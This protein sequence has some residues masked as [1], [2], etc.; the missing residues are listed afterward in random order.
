MDARRLLRI[1]LQDHFAAA[2]AGVALARRV[3]AANA[4]GA[5]GQELWRLAEEV[6]ADRWTMAEVLRS[7]DVEPSL[8]KGAVARVAESVSRAKPNGRLAGYSPLSRVLELETLAAGITA[9]AALW[10]SLDLALGRRRGD[11]DFRALHRS[12]LDQARRAEQL[13]AE[14][15]RLA[16]AQP[17]VHAERT[18]A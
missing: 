11:I 12:A 6:A 4:E 17:S 3:H 8:V 13:R 9:K 15:A 1:Y 16:F 10:R 2:G 7:L 5:F 14:A 18:A